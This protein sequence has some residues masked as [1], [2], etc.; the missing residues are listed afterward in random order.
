MPVISAATQARDEGYFR[1]EW[2]LALDRSHLMAH[3][4]PFLLPVVIDA[5]S[6]AAARVPPEF[7][8][9]QWTRLPGGAAPEKFCLRVRHLLG[10][11]V[12]PVS[13]RPI[14]EA[15]KLPALRT[16]AVA[17]KSIAVLAFASLSPDPENEYFSDGISEDLIGMLG[18]VPGLTV[19]GRTSAFSFKGKNVPMPEIARQLDVTYVVRGS[20]RRAGNR[21]RVAVE[22]SRAANDELV[23]ASEPMERELKDVF[24]VQDEVVALIAKNLSLKLGGAARAART[25]DPEAHRLVLEGQ[26]FWNRG[27]NADVVHATAVFAKAVEVD[28]GF[29]DAHAGVAKAGVLSVVYRWLEGGQGD[30]AELR[31]AHESAER[32]LRLDPAH[33]DAL[34]VLAMAH[35]MEAKFDECERRL[36]ESLAINPNVSL[37]HLWCAHL[38][39][40]RGRLAAGM[41]ALSRAMELDPCLF[42]PPLL[43]A[44][45]MVEARRFPESLDLADRAAAILGVPF[46]PNLGYR[47]MALRGL[48]RD[49][50]AVAAARVMRARIAEQP[51]WGIDAA[52]VEVLRHAGEPGEAEAYADEFFATVP[53]NSSSR[54]TVLAVLGRID[55]ALPFLERMPALG[56]R[57]FFWH[58][59]W[60]HWREDARFQQLLEKIGCAEDYQVA[61]AELV[62]MLADREANK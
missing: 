36:Q 30:L 32:A 33:A 4:K 12:A 57:S 54:G 17:E 46:I 16:P 37:T 35:M 59:F 61:R 26:F 41:A 15:G 5:T 58:S 27:S 44:L 53:A 50:E 8:A 52:A 10:G 24:A 21:V 60:D 31:H 62:R 25:V 11:E 22:L 34:T 45:A 6:D 38:L 1:L 9:V 29:A 14:E 48:G 47:I 42:V 18:R 28:P 51:R 3:D 23:W 39:V 55:E 40:N 7:R 56:R 20:V 49:A 13:S 19:R 2:K 43:Q